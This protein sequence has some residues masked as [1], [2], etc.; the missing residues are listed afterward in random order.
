MILNH[1]KLERV[2]TFMKYLVSV[3][4]LHFLQKALFWNK[5]GVSCIKSAETCR[6]GGKWPTRDFLWKYFPAD[7]RRKLNGHKIYVRSIYVLC[8]RGY[9]YLFTYPI[10]Q[11][12]SIKY[13]CY[14]HIETSQLICT[15]N[16]LTGSYMRATLSLNGLM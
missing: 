3:A 5:N 7:T 12:L 14:P 11:R 15:A 8:L 10:Y 2:A 6:T 4:C 16:Q 13:Q 1:V 9:H